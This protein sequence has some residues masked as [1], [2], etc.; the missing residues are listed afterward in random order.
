MS[1]SSRLESTVIEAA[2][3]RVVTLFAQPDFKK[4]P[5]RAVWRRV[6]WRLHWKTHP[7]D[8]VVLSNWC[9]G[10]RIILPRSGSA[11]QIFYR[12][13][14]SPGVV[15]FLNEFLKPGMTILDIGAHIGEYSLIA[16]R[17]VGPQGVVHAFEPQPN[18]AAV[19]SQNAAIN[20]F[21]WL[22]VHPCAVSDHTRN[23]LFAAD[24][25]SRAGWLVEKTIM[26]E[27]L[28]VETTTLDHFCEERALKQIDFIKIDA[29]GNEFSALT[30]GQDLLTGPGAPALAVKL[31]HPEV[32]Q[33][34]FGYDGREIV[35]LLLDWN[36]RLYDLTSRQP[37]PFS[38][39]VQGYCIPVLA[40]R[41]KL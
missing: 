28:E 15:A 10:L 6:R 17:L 9:N 13:F 25:G 21:S 2:L 14:S 23:Q 33:D 8:S 12:E 39:T 5:V 29:A 22:I 7:S 1:I 27:T 19:I 30:G 41:E 18:L 35:R 38:G 37:E 26:Q 3:N 20:K 40:T 36:Y 24:P 34:R 16:A 11:A 32:T 4:N 31:Y